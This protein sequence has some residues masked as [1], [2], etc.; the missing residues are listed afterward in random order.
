[1]VRRDGATGTVIWDALHPAKPFASDRD[2][3]RWMRGAFD[4]TRPGGLLEQVPDLNGD[5]VGDL[6]LF[7]ALS[8]AVL[9]VSG[10]DGS[11]LWNYVAE[12]NGQGGPRDL[13]PE[14]VGGCGRRA[15]SAPAD[16]R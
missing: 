1:M 14:A 7:N 15:S 10:K 5:G 4:P 8:P 3:V 2:P 11:M 12:L 9:A 13:C 6:V 16:Q